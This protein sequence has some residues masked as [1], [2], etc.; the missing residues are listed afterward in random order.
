MCHKFGQDILVWSLWCPQG[1]FYNDQG[2]YNFNIKWLK[3]LIKQILNDQFQQILLSNMHNSSKA[4]N[5][6]LF[7]ENC[8]F[9]EYL[10]LL[11]DN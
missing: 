10:D 2:L 3:E 11:N 1:Y 7:K 9:E 5:Y 6:K 4:A 8:E